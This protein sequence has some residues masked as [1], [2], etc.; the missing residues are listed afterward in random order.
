[1]PGLKV[2]II[3]IRILL[4]SASDSLPR[5]SCPSS[6][7]AVQAAWSTWDLW[8]RLCQP[9]ATLAAR[10]HLVILK[11]IISTARRPSHKE[12]DLITGSQRLQFRGRTNRNQVR[13]ARG[14]GIIIGHGFRQQLH[15]Q[16][17]LHH[18]P[19]T[20]ISSTLTASTLHPALAQAL[21]F[22]NSVSPRQLK[23]SCECRPDSLVNAS[24]S[25]PAGSIPLDIQSRHRLMLSP[26]YEVTVNV[27]EDYLV[28][29]RALLRSML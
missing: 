16:Q 20:R 9:A 11:S 21:A 14:T 19:Y 3:L 17:Y 26:T 5:P 6:V 1:M 24:K 29:R 2:Q 15:L 27:S 22:H 23:I 12:A 18:S 4:V 7:P 10:P 28:C 13:H 8:H 25:K